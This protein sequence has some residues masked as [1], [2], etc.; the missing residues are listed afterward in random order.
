MTDNTWLHEYLTKLYCMHYYS[1]HFQNICSI[2]L[3]ALCALAIKSQLNPAV[4]VQQD[5]A[6]NQHRV[7][8]PSL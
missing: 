8:Q 7:V 1:E 6:I 4:T 2:F 5:L 3:L